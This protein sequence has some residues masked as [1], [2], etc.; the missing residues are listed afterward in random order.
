M[1]PRHLFLAVV[2]IPFLVLSGFAVAQHGFSGIFAVAW[3]S[4]AGAQV[5]AD[6]CIALFI[7]FGW[8]RE[9]ALRRGLNP[10]PWMI[11]APFLGSISPLFYLVYREFHPELEE[12]RAWNTQAA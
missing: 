12:R 8:I 4:T 11:A 9:D 10:L 2:M 1:K 3:S 5:F 6:L 7:A